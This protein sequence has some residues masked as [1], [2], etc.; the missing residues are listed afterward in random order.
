[1]PHPGTRRRGG[2]KREADQWKRWGVLTS[3]ARLAVLIYELLRGHVIGNG[4][5]PWYLR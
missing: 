5:G 3:A 4:P 2:K 1:M